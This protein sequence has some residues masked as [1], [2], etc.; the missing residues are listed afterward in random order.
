MIP[1][2]QYSI[3]IQTNTPMSRNYEHAKNLLKQYGSAAPEFSLDKFCTYGRV[4]SVYDGDS[5]KVVMPVFD[6]CY[7]FNVRLCGIDTCEMKSKQSENK[8]R[9]I[10]ARNRLFGLITKADVDLSVKHSTRQMTHL[11]E[12]D[13]FLVWLE[14]QEFDKYGRVLANVSERQGSPFFSDIL[15]DEKL[16]YAYQGATKLTEEQQVDVLDAPPLPH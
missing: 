12:S 8:K 14:C 7:K 13:V 9:A 5:I 15:L 11:L 4:V 6:S 16:A 10:A 2:T 1:S 3:H